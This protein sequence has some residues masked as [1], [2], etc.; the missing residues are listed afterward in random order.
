LP[1]PDLFQALVSTPCWAS[2]CSR[3]PIVHVTHSLA[4]ARS[5]ADHVIE[6]D[7]DRV[8]GEGSPRDVLVS[9]AE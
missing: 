4:E 9:D 3:V 2:I 6:L 7:R 5:L 1:L 8:I